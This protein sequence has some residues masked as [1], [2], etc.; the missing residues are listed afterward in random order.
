MLVDLNQVAAPLY[1]TD[2]TVLAFELEVTQNNLGG[3][4]LVVGPASIPLADAA[5]GVDFRTLASLTQ[6]NTPAPARLQL[7]PST[8]D[9]ATRYD[10]LALITS[11]LAPTTTGAVYLSFP[12]AK[13]NTPDFNFGLTNLRNFSAGFN[14]LSLPNFASLVPGFNLANDLSGLIPGIEDMPGSLGGSFGDFLGNPFP[15]TG[16]AIKDFGNII[17][18]FGDGLLSS[19]TS[20][21]NNLVASTL[22]SSLQ[23]WLSVALGP[24]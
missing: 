23:T 16:S 24:A 1:V 18:D 10:P 5:D 12:N 11:G 17:A 3:V 4:N 22:Q 15:L 20:H 13:P 8:T 2:N 21:A 6:L 14:G 19:L 9:A 7:R